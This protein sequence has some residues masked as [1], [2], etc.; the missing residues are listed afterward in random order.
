MAHAF[1]L[2]LQAQNHVPVLHR[3]LSKHILLDSDG[4]NGEIW[5]QSTGYEPRSRN[6]GLARGAWNK[7]GRA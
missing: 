4:G 5:A 2:S 6:D 3:M 1:V 7:V